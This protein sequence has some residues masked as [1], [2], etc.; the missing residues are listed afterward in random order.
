MQLNFAHICFV[1]VAA[2]RSDHIV[3]RNNKLWP[4]DIFVSQHACGVC[5]QTDADLFFRVL[6]DADLYIC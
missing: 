2:G 4:I 6:T 1:R 5:K 3:F